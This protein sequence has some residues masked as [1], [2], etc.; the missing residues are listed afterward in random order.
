MESL[1]GTYRWICQW[2]DRVDVVCSAK[3]FLTLTL[4]AGAKASPEA[5][6]G[7]FQAWG[8]T[9]HFT[10]LV[11]TEHSRESY[12]N[13]WAIDKFNWEELSDKEQRELEF[14]KQEEEDD[15]EVSVLDVKDDNGNPFI[16]FYLNCGCGR[17]GIREFAMFM[18]MKKKDGDGE[19]ELLKTELERSN[20]D[21]DDEEIEEEW[22]DQ[23]DGSGSDDGSE[24]EDN[25]EGEE[26]AA[27]GKEDVAAGGTKRKRTKKAGNARRDA[28]PQ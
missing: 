18:G 22:G 3:G 19:R 15:H 7:T 4:K 26:S 16:L 24:V 20:W 2:D 10:S 14:E 9:G 25:S 17:A 13:V 1:C 5:I 11:Q 28:T 21:M 8:Q 27:S 23:S 12:P 6:G